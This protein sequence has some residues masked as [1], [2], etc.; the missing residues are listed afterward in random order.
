MSLLPQPSP[1]LPPPPLL[2]TSICGG[3]SAWMALSYQA[4]A[5]SRRPITQTLN[6]APS[7]YRARYYFCQ[8][9]SLPLSLCICVPLPECLSVR[10]SKDVCLCRLVVLQSC[11]AHSRPTRTIHSVSQ[12]VAP[13]LTRH[14]APHIHLQIYRIESDFRHSDQP[15]TIIII[16]LSLVSS[17]L[18]ALT[19]LAW[20]TLYFTLYY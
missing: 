5:A 10:L 14:R 11:S 3:R 15:P 2:C 6:Y 19:L 7:Y 17:T 12:S 20:L 9:L 13:D 18:C 4:T 1:P 8:A 16:Y